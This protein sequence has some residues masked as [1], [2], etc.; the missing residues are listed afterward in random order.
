MGLSD[1]LESMIIGSCAS[2]NDVYR[3]ARA[4][5]PT[6]GRPD[7]LFVRPTKE[8]NF[9]REKSGLN[10]VSCALTIEELLEGKRFDPARL[11]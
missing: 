3:T 6:A 7:Y 1:N 2:Q 8:R 5:W 11:A 9:K 4:H 10:G